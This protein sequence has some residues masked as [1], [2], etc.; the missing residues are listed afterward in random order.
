M[1]IEY[2]KE[3]VVK[4]HFKKKALSKLALSISFFL[5]LLT[6]TGYIFN[7][8]AAIFLFYIFSF[9]FIYNLL[10]NFLLEKFFYKFKKDENKTEKKNFIDGEFEDIEDDNDKKI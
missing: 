9:A 8:K 5:V 2:M 7:S 10:I 4:S 6:S 1:L 3:K